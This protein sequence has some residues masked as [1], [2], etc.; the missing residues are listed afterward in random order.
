MSG[1]ACLACMYLRSCSGRGG[2]SRGWLWPGI[3]TGGVRASRR[4]GAGPARVAVRDWVPQRNPLSGHVRCLLEGILAFTTTRLPLLPY[5][6]RQDS[7]AFCLHNGNWNSWVARGMIFLYHLDN[8][9]TVQNKINRT[10][11][12]GF[13]ISCSNVG[14]SSCNVA[15][16]LVSPALDSIAMA[17]KLLRKG[18]IQKTWAF[19]C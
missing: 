5:P 12:L 6:S 13:W 18:I 2:R 4:G 8:E 11:L 3:G 10:Y 16:G 15:W 9:Q 14:V 7:Q 17:Y 1:R 19:S